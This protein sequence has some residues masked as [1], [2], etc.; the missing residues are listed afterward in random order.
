MLI[1]TSLIPD[2]FYTAVS[3]ETRV[4]IEFVHNKQ[5]LVSGNIEMT[6]SDFI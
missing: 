5:D 4:I 6:S 1:G 3:D 2:K